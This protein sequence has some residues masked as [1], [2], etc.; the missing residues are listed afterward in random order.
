M[1]FFEIQLNIYENESLMRNSWPQ[2]TFVVDL[3]I[4]LEILTFAII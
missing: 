1:V 3:S 2:Q 4:L